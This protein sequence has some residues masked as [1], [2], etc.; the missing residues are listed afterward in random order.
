MYRRAADRGDVGA[1]V[2]LAG[3]REQAGDAAD[4][5]ALAVQAA[6]LGHASALRD[7]A[8]RR[9]QAGDADAGRMRKFGLTGSGDV[10]KRLDFGS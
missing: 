6:D 9:E 3:L 2:R 5:E 7:L 4:A 8:W 10:A 1:L